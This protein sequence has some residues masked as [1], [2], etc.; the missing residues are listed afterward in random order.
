M[1]S[2]NALDSSLSTGVQQQSYVKHNNV[3]PRILPILILLVITIICD[4]GKLV[5]SGVPANLLAVDPIDSGQLPGG[6]SEH[7]H[8][9]PNAGQQLPIGGE[10]NVVFFPVI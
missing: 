5:A 1:L 2:E 9:G 7:L 6:N 4:N 10:A 3:T 8:F